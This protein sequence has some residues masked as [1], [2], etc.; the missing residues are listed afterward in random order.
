MEVRTLAPYL[1]CLLLTSHRIWHDPV[2]LQSA[3]SPR[4]SGLCDHVFLTSWS[5][6]TMLCSSFLRHSS[7]QSIPW[8]D[9]APG[10]SFLSAATISSLA[11]HRCSS[12]PNTVKE[13]T[14]YPWSKSW[15]PC[16]A[17][18]M[19]RECSY[20]WSCMSWI[21]LNEASATP[22]STAS[23]RLLW[24][25]DKAEVEHMARFICEVSLYHKDFVSTKPSIMARTSIALAKSILGCHGTLNLDQIENWTARTLS[26]RLHEISQI[27]V[28]KYSSLHLSLFFYSLR[29]FS[30]TTSNY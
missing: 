8:I 20:R 23:S 24:Q 17:H 6:P 7:S 30:G 5:K 14:V 26:E 29:A 10:V 21:L 9:T 18:C 11:V 25:N 1:L 27:L 3:L 19:T 2:M 22:P 4:F 15:R 16:A 13:K 12:L 28:S